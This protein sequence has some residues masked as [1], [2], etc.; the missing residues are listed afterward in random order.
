M[1]ILFFGDSI[2]AGSDIPAG[3]AS[4]AW[5][6]IVPEF[7]KW[8]LDIVNKSRGGRPTDSIDEFREA[9]ASTG[10]A[11]ILAIALGANDSRDFT[12]ACAATATKNIGEMVQIARTAGYSCIVIVGPYNMNAGCWNANEASR[13]H[14]VR[15]LVALDEAYADF[16]RQSRLDYVSMYGVVPE[17]SM[18]HDG[19]H[20]DP[21]GNRPIAERFAAALLE[22]AR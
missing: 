13:A 21:P 19:V 9:L 18:T 20:P 6:Y 22:F 8:P 14:R 11:D 3:T 1:R 15:N 10:T 16:C 4:Y 2:C 5:P 12:G 17:S 7:V